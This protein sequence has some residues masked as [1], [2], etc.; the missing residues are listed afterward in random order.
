MGKDEIFK[1]ENAPELVGTA[2]LRLIPNSRLKPDAKNAVVWPHLGVKGKTKLSLGIDP[3]PILPPPTGIDELDDRTGRTNVKF[4]VPK[5]WS[6]GRLQSWLNC[7]RKAWYNNQHGLGRDEKMSEDVAAATRGNIVHMIE[8]RILLSHGLVEGEIPESPIPLDSGPLAIPDYALTTVLH[9]LEDLAPWLGRKDGVSFFRSQ[10][11][12]GASPA[13]WSNWVEHKF[14]FK[15]GGKIG[16][17]LDADMQANGVAPIASEWNLGGSNFS[18]VSLTLPEKPSTVL[19]LRGRIDRVDSVLIN[20]DLVKNDIT[21]EIPLDIS[22]GDRPPTSRLVIIRDLKSVDG[23]DKEGKN[24]HKKSLFEQLQLALY[25]RS[26]EIEHPGDRVI[27]VGVTSVGSTTTHW[28]EIDPEYSEE[29]AKLNVGEL[30]GLT[31][32]H[33][34]LPDSGIDC[35]SNPFR[36]WM[37]ERLTTALRVIKAVE[38]GNIHPEPSHLCNYCPIID[39]C[40]TGLEELSGI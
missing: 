24:K 36:A 2:G 15:L 16:G 23:G 34:R 35:E 32:E 30:T 8:E 21:E 6:Q 33:Y 12:I 3:R 5:V 29:L 7:P 17:L 1:F 22:I 13:L 25:A 9:G 11:L 19:K 39:A 20:S 4:Q 14:P 18:H 37:R 40:P 31:H 28:V 27:G 38:N 10:T 26:W